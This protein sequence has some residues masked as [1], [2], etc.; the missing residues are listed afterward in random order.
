MGKKTE[1]KSKPKSPKSKSKPTKEVKP[2][3]PKKE[4]KEQFT[5]LFLEYYLGWHEGES[6][7][8][9]TMSFLMARG[10]DKEQYHELCRPMVYEE[11]EAI[12]AEDCETGEVGLAIVKR[13]VYH[14]VYANARTESWRM[15]TNPYTR[16]L[17][18]VMLAERFK[19]PNH[20]KNRHQ[21]LADQNKNLI[22]ARQANT[23]ILKMTAGLEDKSSINIP[24]LEALTA[25]IGGILKPS[26]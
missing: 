26:K 18:E 17:K 3:S 5:K 1:T 16:K 2:I 13:K 7:G 25:K 20:A 11:E 12:N 23:D 24:Q 22:V 6:F 15:L 8:N 10:Y 19:D 9:A 21:Q 4:I 14:P